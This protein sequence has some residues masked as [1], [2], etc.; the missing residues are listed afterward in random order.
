MKRCSH[1][2]LFTLLASFAYGQFGPG[3]VGTTASNGMWLRAGDLSGAD[4]D[5]V[6]TWS[7]FS[8]YGNNAA[9]TDPTKRPQFFNTSALNNQPIIRLDGGNDEMA[10]L[11]NPVLDN[12]AGITYYAVLRPNNLNGSPRGIL[13]KRVTFTVST[14]Y[15]YTWFFWS[16]NRLN[17]DVHTQNNRYNSGG[18]TFAN[19]T[20]YI[21]SFDFDGSLPAAQRSRMFSNGVKIAQASETSTALPNSNQDVAIGALNVGYGTYLGADYGEV[22]HYNYSLDSAEHIIVSNYLAAK[23]GIT[24]GV[25][26]LYDEDDFGNGDYDF[27]VCGIG[28]I[29]GTIIHDDSQSDAM[30]RINSPTDLNDTEFMFWGHDGAGMF[31]YEYADIPAGTQ[32]RLNRVW[33]VSEVNTSGTP[34]DVGSVDITWD[35]SAHGPVTASD[36][37]LLIDTDGDGNFNTSTQVSGATDLGG[38]AYQFAGISGLTDNIRFTLATI[39]SSQTPLPIELITF[40]AFTI[41]QQSVEIQWETASEINNDYFSIERSVDGQFWET[42]EEVNGAGN[43]NQNIQYETSDTDPHLGISYYRLK[44]TDFDG[45][46]SYSDIRS[47]EIL[48]ETDGVRLYPNPTNHIVTVEGDQKELED[49]K[50][51]NLLG[52][53]ITESLNVFRPTNRIIEIDFSGKS[54]GV[55]LLK[56]RTGTHPIHKQ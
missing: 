8:A 47:V 4:G 23:Y 5:P 28:Q 52:Q 39:N 24:L 51:Y 17:N 54:N 22:I 13:G 45:Q 27:Q 42:I 49:V 40:D 15:A 21:L 2:I 36:L 9:Q 6:P 7:D 10:I 1:F 11:D 41:D 56:T 35:L 3:G 31:A 53:D 30:V 38:G 43:S 14:Q 25:N 26:D 44:Q 50:V 55:Y 12:T 29:S 32:A 33:R 19:A 20:N 18:N 34:V 46:F 16:G 37:R 48:G